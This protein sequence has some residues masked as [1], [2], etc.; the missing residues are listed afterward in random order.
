MDG[1]TYTFNENS[2]LHSFDGKPAISSDDYTV[3][4]KGGEHWTLRNAFQYHYKNGVIHRDG[5]L[6]AIY[7]AYKWEG[8]DKFRGSYAFVKNGVAD[9]PNW[10]TRA[11]YNEKSDIEVS[12]K[13]GELHGYMIFGK[14]GKEFGFHNGEQGD[15]LRTGWYDVF[16]SN[17]NIKNMPRNP[18]ANVKEFMEFVDIGPAFWGIP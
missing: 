8:S 9:N 12:C 1:V 16:R 6:P 10:H 15:V 18:C 17:T 2:N 13:N 3:M 7:N 14:Y 5:E 4:N 11:L